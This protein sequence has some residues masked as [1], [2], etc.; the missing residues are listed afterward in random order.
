MT[1][2]EIDEAAVTGRRPVGRIVVRR[3]VQAPIVLLI[4][5]AAVFWLVQVVPGDPG[6]VALGQFATA[7]QVAQWKTDNGLDGS[8]LERYL[9]WLGGFVTGHWGTSLTYGEPVAGLVIERLLNSIF[10]GLYAFVLVLVVGVGVGL[11]QAFRAGSRSDR[12]LT[13]SFVSLSSTPEFAVGTLLLVVFAVFFRWFPVQS[14]V[15]DG[16]SLAA[17]LT[18]TTLPA[19][20][21]AAATVGYV[22]RMV[23][24]GTIETLRSP[25]YRTAVLKGL[26]RRR[27]VSAHV[28]RN[29]LVPAVAVLGGQLAYLIGG[30]AVVETLF[31]YPG[32]GLTIVEAVQKKDLML[33]EGA[34]MVTALASLLVLLI[35]DL[36]YMALDPRID[37]SQEQRA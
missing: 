6:R 12:A 15:P 4:V 30:S 2:I 11:V 31:S 3:L 18:V 17:R 35:T 28:A 13:M 20:T 8:V 25:F 33:L 19:L 7:E 24:A 16:A 32:I 37:L 36:V 21:L 9:G 5:S 22:A 10:L 23:R 34:I 29:S 14:A 26:P 1:R 27:V